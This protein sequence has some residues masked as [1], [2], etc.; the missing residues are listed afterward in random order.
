MRFNILL[1]LL[2]FSFV[3]CASTWKPV[4]VAEKERPIRICDPERDTPEKA[5]EGF[6]YKVKLVKKRLLLPDLFN[7]EEHFWPFSDKAA[8]KKFAD[9]N[10]VLVPE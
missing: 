10:R 1:S 2:L 4:D 9:E 6:C 3:S 8:M 7:V 5:Y